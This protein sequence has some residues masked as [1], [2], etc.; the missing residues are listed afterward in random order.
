MLIAIKII[1][2]VHIVEAA[3]ET[4]I[5]VPNE[6]RLGSAMKV[7]PTN[8]RLESTVEPVKAQLEIPEAGESDRTFEVEPQIIPAIMEESPAQVEADR[9]VP[10][11]LQVRQLLSSSYLLTVFK[12]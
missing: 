6:G 9:P 10:A 3:S 5:I 4:E 12:P 1:K 8:S 11:D 2:E 7:I